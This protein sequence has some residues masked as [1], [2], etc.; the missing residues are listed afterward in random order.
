MAQVH[1]PQGSSLFWAILTPHASASLSV[2]YGAYKNIP[3]VR[4][5][6]TLNRGQTLSVRISC[7]PIFPVSVSLQC[8]LTPISMA[9]IMSPWLHVTPPPSRVQKHQHLQDT[10][11]TLALVS[12]LPNWAPLL[13]SGFQPRSVFGGSETRHAAWLA[14]SSFFSLPPILTAR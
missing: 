11:S 4:L 14:R 6:Q 3:P 7:R 8:C 9:A 12:T 1:L 13:C 2:K 5:L 10:S